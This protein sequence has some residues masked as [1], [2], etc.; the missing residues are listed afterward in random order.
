MMT[1]KDPSPRFRRYSSEARAAMLVEAGLACLARGG[2]TSFTTDHIC[3][4][5]AVSR[6]LITHHFGSKNG[7]LAACYGAMYDRFTTTL[8]PTE[9]EAPGLVQLVEA[10]FDPSV[11]NPD[12]LRIWLALWGEIANNPELRDVHRSRY[13]DFLFLVS[14]AVTACAQSRGLTVNAHSIAI[15]FI[16]LSDGLWL[17]QGIDPT[18]LSRDAAR[19]ACYHFLESFLG[20]LTST[21][22]KDNSTPPLE[23]FG[24][25]AP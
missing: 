18:M 17:E 21:G 12:S 9:G 3:A 19:K 7:L 11:F 1:K 4:E 6:G 22:A 24:T 15:L 16:A 20:P 25:P 23:S 14:R 10:S 8:L 13:Q 2:I 5:A